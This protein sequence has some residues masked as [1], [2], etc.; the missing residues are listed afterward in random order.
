MPKVALA[1]FNNDVASNF[2]LHHHGDLNQFDY[3]VLFWTMRVYRPGDHIFDFGGGL[4][5][6]RYAYDAYIPIQGG[7]HW[8]VCDV[9][10]LAAKGAEIAAG[11]NQGDLHF[12]T[13]FKDAARARI[14]ITNGNLQYIPEDFPALL[15]ALSS[16]P[17]H[18]LIN[19]IPAY[20]G[21]AFYTVQRTRHRSYTPCRG[22]NREAFAGAIKALGYRLIDSWEVNR[23]LYV[24]FQPK[25]YVPTYRGFYFTR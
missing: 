16:R 14:L 5:Q 15:A 9:P 22:V 13:D 19:R 2:Y 6:C 7:S 24:N 21:E 18:L 17:V 10:A 20:E 23:S 3:P 8:V 25:Y 11:R 12:T 1:G 4:G